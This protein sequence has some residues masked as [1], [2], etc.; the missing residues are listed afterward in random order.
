V[1]KPVLLWIGDAVVSSGFSKCTREILDVV[2][3]DWEV[4]VLGLNYIGDPHPLPYSIY[5]CW[6]GGDMFGLGRTAGLVSDLRPEVVVIQNDPWNIPEYLKRIQGGVPVVGSCPVDGLNCRG[7]GLEKCASVVFWTEFG[8]REARKGGYTGPAAVVPMGVDLDLFKPMDRSQAHARLGL[9]QQVREGFVVGNVN[10]N[11]PRKRLDLTISFFADWVKAYDVRDAYL[12]LHV[13]PTGDSGYDVRQL[14]RYYGL[15]DRLILAEPEIGYG[16]REEMVAWT[17]GS[18]DVQM[19]T[20]Q[21][22]GWG[23]TTMEGMACGIP[24][25][26]PDWAAL[27]D[28]ARTAAVA[29]P[30]REICT[31][32]SNINVLG[33]VPD[34]TEFVAGLDLLY[35]NP[36]RR[37]ELRER[38]LELVSRPEYRWREVGERYREV[39]AMVRESRKIASG[40]LGLVPAAGN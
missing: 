31:T 33:G 38:G 11:Q 35:N 24:Q 12:F 25:I 10:R 1:K 21:G 14:M 29:V 28:W 22:E 17:Y 13:A 7:A 8:L 3:E 9:P 2:R 40:P 26:F 19:S 18:F 23:L 37:A 32:P 4:H 6:P 5:T 36:G 16:A 27:G 39:L 20:S 30:C 15:A 34:R